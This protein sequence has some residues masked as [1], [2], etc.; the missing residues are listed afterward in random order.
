MRTERDIWMVTG[1]IDW[2]GDISGYSVEALDGGIGKIDEATNESTGAF[3][4][5]DTGP[6]IFGKKV[7]LPAGV[8]DRLDHDSETVFVNRTKDQIKKRRSSIRTP[9]ARSRTAAP[10]AATTAKVAPATAGAETTCSKRPLDAP[11]AP[12][13]RLAGPVLLGRQKGASAAMSTTPSRAP[14]SATG[15]ACP[16]AGT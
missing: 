12:A 13:R 6:W 9:T 8:I 2:T 15:G 16:T 14:A 5:V 3:L 10:S 1:Q 4:V 7:L 11:P